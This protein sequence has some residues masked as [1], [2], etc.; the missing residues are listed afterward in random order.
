MS[1]ESARKS[2]KLAQKRKSAKDK[3]VDLVEGTMFLATKDGSFSLYRW[4]DEAG[5]FLEI[6]SGRLLTSEE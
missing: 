6:G 5:D 2:R 1:T 4:D 3:G